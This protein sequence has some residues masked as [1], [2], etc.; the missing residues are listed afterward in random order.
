LRY[1][2]AVAELLSFT[3]AARRLRV[4]Q[5]SVTRQ[6]ALLEQE[7]A[8]QL[9]RRSKHHV[10][11]TEAGRVF[12]DQ[13]GRLF[14]S[15]DAAVA[16]ARRAAQG[17]TGT[18][19][20]GYGGASVYL[21]APV[22]QAFR[23][24]FPGVELAFSF[25]HLGYQLA[26]IRDGDIDVGLVVQPVNDALLATKAFAVERLV[27]A[28]PSNH[29]LRRRA[30][31]SLSE[32]QHENF[33]MVPWRQ[34]FGFGRPTMRM[35]SRAGFVPNIVQEVEPMDSV[36]GLVSAGVGIALVPALYSHLP[37]PKVLYRPLRDRF[38]VAEIALAWRADNAS[39]IVRAFVASA[40][41]RSAGGS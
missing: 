33:V 19:K 15:M 11:L 37:M 30:R 12:Y 24:A 7:L 1:F 18:L 14:T 8:L 40:R 25:H 4:S 16:M 2:S 23:A 29:P 5:P 38:A 36:L 32:L 6:V 21:L 13:V 27:V 31:L 41:I 3:A 35:C 39:P 20:I 28:I 34:G 26:A 22:L 9:L 10:E 17:E